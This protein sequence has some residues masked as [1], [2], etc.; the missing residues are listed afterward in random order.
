VLMFVLY[1]TGATTTRSIARELLFVS[2]PFALLGLPDEFG[3]RLMPYFVRASAVVLGVQGL[4]CLCALRWFR[5]RLGIAG[6]VAMAA[7]VALLW[8]GASSAACVQVA[9][10]FLL[11]HSLAWRLDAKGAQLLR[12]VAG[13]I[14]LVNAAL[15]IHAAPW[16]TDLG[17]TLSALLLLGAWFAIWRVSRERPDLSLAT[18]AGTV[19]CFAPCDWLVKN[20]SPGLIAL[21]AS[22]FLFVI[23][24]V[25]AWTRQH[26]ETNG[27]GR[28]N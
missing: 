28:K 8:P 4:V 6:A 27:A 10:L 25:L 24:F 20:G 15:W 23:G 19:A 18:F 3:Q 21:A 26:W 12:L 7:I 22:V 16:R 11:T 2:F 17:I 9:V 14:W 5:L 13:S 1:R